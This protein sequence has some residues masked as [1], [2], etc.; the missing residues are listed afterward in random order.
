[1]VR[2]STRRSCKPCSSPTPSSRGS[3]SAQEPR[4]GWPIYA[5][6]LGPSGTPESSRSRNHGS[7]PWTS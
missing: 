4:S 6:R 2:S 3:R 1:M 5:S 7:F